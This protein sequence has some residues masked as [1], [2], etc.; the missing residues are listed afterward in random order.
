MR[1]PQ[2]T[3]EMKKPAELMPAGFFGIPWIF[4]E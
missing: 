3:L 2:T 1:R 4:W